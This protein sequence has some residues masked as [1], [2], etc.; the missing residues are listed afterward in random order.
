MRGKKND[1]V[2][3]SG[4]TELP[5]EILKRAR[6]V[7][8]DEESSRS[9]T[10]F[11]L[12][13]SAVLAG[14][15][16]LFKGKLE[17]LSMKE[18]L[19]KYEWVREKYYR[20]LVGGK[21]FEGSDDVE[22]S[23]MDG[24]FLRIF[25]EAEVELPLQAIMFI[26]KQGF[27]QKVRNLVIAEE[28]SNAKVVTGCTLSVKS[29][30]HFG[31]TEFF[32]E[33]N[34]TLNFTMIHGWAEDA[35]VRPVAVTLI[36]DN[37]DFVSNYICLRPAQ[38]LK[39]Y[40]KAICQGENSKASFNNIIYTNRDSLMDVGSEIKLEGGGS[41]GEI[42]SRTVAEERS[43]AIIRGRLIG[44]NPRSKAHLECRG[45]LQD[46]A[47]IHAIPEL[48]ADSEGAELSHEAAVGRIAEKEINYLMSRGLTRDEAT[49]VIV[50]GF[51]DTSI[52]GLPE[53]LD[54]E[55]KAMVEKIAKGL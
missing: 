43:K 19:S 22:G 37:A 11:Q 39:M 30:Q 35:K 25:P 4:F 24:Y 48:I 9:G 42:I 53:A 5:G 14:V 23:F 27:R 36:G 29:A 31:I 20:R 52:M 21:G 32:V 8:G 15:N 47:Y 3:I 7:G 12:D 44:N 54:E 49:S 16:E 2:G 33:E 26:S 50:R 34:A 10:F 28:G 13:E 38:N 45:I 40:P 1:E 51:M 46:D 55:I 6:E 41:R 17:I 18:A